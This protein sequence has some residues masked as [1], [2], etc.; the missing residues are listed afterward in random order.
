M[1]KKTDTLEQTGLNF[2]QH[3]LRIERYACLFILNNIYLPTIC[4]IRFF[5]FHIGSGI[6]HFQLIIARCQF[7]HLKIDIVF[8]NTIS[9]FIKD[10]MIYNQGNLI[11]LVDNVYID[12]SHGAVGCNIFKRTLGNTIFSQ[13]NAKDRRLCIIF[14]IEIRTCFCWREI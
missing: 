5:I 1:K 9:K 3:L 4:N 13:L 12:I 14:Q 8:T 11:I 7:A 10:I 2:R 6:V